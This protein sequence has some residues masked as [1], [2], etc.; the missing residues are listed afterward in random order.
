MVN[1]FDRPGYTMRKGDVRSDVLGGH[2]MGDMP[3]WWTVC[4]PF[5]AVDVFEVG[6]EFRWPGGHR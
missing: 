1:W 2:W 4:E 5:L 6:A 3:W